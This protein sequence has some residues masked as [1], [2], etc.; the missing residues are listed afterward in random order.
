MNTNSQIWPMIYRGT[1]ST[2]NT[3]NAEYMHDNYHFAPC[4]GAA[5]NYDLVHLYGP[6]L[7]TL[8]IEL[9][10]TPGRSSPDSY[11]LCFLR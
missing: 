10:C 1:C 7:H 3:A 11:S 8:L 2:K 9:C 6:L 4:P 5:P